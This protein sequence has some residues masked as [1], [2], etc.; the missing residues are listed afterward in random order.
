[1]DGIGEIAGGVSLAKDAYFLLSYFRK[2]ALKFF[3]KE[4]LPLDYFESKEITVI[5]SSLFAPPHNPQ[6][7]Y[8]SLVKIGY[9]DRGVEPVG[10]GFLVTGI[11]DALALSKLSIALIERG[12]V[13]SIGVD[14]VM[15]QVKDENL[16]LLGGPTS[17]LI[18]KKIYDNYLSPKHRFL[19]EDGG[20]TVHGN[21]FHGGEYGHILFM[22]SPFN[23]SKKL[24]WLAGLGPFGTGS[25]VDF[26]INRFKDSAPKELM[27]DSDWIL[28]VRGVP[29]EK[30]DIL[31][32]NPI[33]H[34]IV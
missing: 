29:S 21:T 12:A 23:R 30:G 10:S 19:S 8:Y 33:G 28:F 25:A 11:Y 27:R 18:G 6:A 20:L 34:V 31:E 16:C 9:S 13:L 14:T 4:S 5:C 26:L 24:L 2:K 17:N 1:M 7:N 32:I 15:E 3:K 22:T